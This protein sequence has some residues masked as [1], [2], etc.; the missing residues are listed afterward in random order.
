MSNILPLQSHL[1]SPLMEADRCVKCGLCL[2]V[3]P[4][5]RL[6]SDENE[7]PRGRIALA[8]ALLQE[9]LEPGDRIEKHLRNCLGCRQCE[10][11]CP[12][13]V[14][15]MKLLDAALARIGPRTGLFG[16]ASRLLQH[17]GLL[18]PLNRLARLAPGPIG[19]LARSLGEGA[20]APAPGEYPAA[21]PARGR[22]G[23]LL[24]CATR[25]QQGSTLQAGIH[26]LN[27]LGYVVSIPT[28]QA[29]CGALAQHTGDRRGRDHQ[30]QQN[31]AAFA[32]VDQVLSI[33]SGCSVQL[34][35]YGAE[36]GGMDICRFLD[37]VE[38]W[39]GLHFSAPQASYLLHQPCSL[40][41]GLRDRQ[42]V[43][44]LLRRVDPAGE[45]PLLG[46]PGDCCGAGG[47]QL[48]SNRRQL[49]RIRQPLLQQ[50]LER[51]PQVL[52]T[53]NIGCA[54]N[55]AQGARPQLPDLRV[56]HPVEWLAL[57]LLPADIK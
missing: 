43:L 2:P 56:M 32:G 57:H 51:R 45:T 49:E 9:R 33:A 28:G 38:D 20:A 22:V 54:M 37:Q 39:P 7:S 6:Y 10:T 29:C 52:L 53:T 23:L 5:Y 48:L 24:G 14:G 36:F 8:E 55:L 26:L 41:N 42:S 15:Y 47:D 30:M 21:S 34:A 11:A 16:G 13:D 17:Q 18:P 25:V 44:R 40:I 27:Q 19:A 31:R 12:S 1:D 4:T 35:E 46:S 3:C 50:L